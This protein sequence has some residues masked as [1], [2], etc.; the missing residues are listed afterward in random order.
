MLRP[1]A[2]LL[3]FFLAMVGSSDALQAQVTVTFKIDGKPVVNH[4]FEL[5]AKD[6]KTTRRAT[7]TNGVFTTPSGGPFALSTVSPYVVGVKKYSWV[8]VIPTAGQVTLTEADATVSEEVLRLSTKAWC[9]DATTI[10]WRGPESRIGSGVRLVFEPQLGVLVQFGDDKFVDTNFKGLEKIGVET[11]LVEGYIGFQALFIYPSSVEFDAQSR[12]V[13]DSIVLDKSGKVDVE[14]G[15][16]FGFT[17]LDG[18]IATGYGFLHYDKR[19]FRE[20]AT[21]KGST[22]G[23]GFFYLNIQPVSAIKSALKDIR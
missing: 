17:F 4:E 13:L 12:S 16:A 8:A 9:A 5:K 3:L 21:L 2:G 20:P 11:N 22:F 23:D 14:F 6:G 15:M 7:D 1:H 10:C 18:I 19:D